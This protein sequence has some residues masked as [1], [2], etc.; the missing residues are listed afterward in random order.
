MKLYEK[1]MKTINILEKNLGIH[2][3]QNSCNS[4]SFKYFF[5]IFVFLE[6]SGD[7]DI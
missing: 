2:A 6:T 7:F 4:S 1:S 3:Q 5:S